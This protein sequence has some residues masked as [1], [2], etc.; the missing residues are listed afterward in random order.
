[1]A[2]QTTSQQRPEVVV[3]GM[4]VMGVQEV[5]LTEWLAQRILQVVELKLLEERV[6]FR[7]ITILV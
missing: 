7:S 5:V 2:Q 4:A 3:A 1:V 6:E